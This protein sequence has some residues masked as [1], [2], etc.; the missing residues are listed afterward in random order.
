MQD[1]IS[2]LDL[3]LTEPC[4]VNISNMSTELIDKY[5]R[6]WISDDGQIQY[7]KP[8]GD[9]IIIKNISIG[10]CAGNKLILRINDIVV[11]TMALEQLRIL[12][13]CCE[14]AGYKVHSD[15]LREI[16]SHRT[17]LNRTLF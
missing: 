11:P 8:N 10:N 13:N 6:F 7:R 3:Y 2:P 15:L 14:K 17:N 9:D 12:L 4:S 16:D 5:G 1:E